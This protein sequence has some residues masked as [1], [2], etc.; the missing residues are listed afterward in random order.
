ME[1][2][3]PKGKHDA[4]SKSINTS[5]TLVEMAPQ[6]KEAATPGGTDIGTKP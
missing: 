1:T 4:L 6:S 2:Y 3:Q 5:P